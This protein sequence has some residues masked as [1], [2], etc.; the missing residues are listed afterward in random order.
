MEASALSLRSRCWISDAL[1]DQPGEEV[2]RDEK[3]AP[4]RIKLRGRFGGNGLI[5]RTTRTFE[6]RNLFA[7]GDEHVAIDY[8]LSPIAYGT[9]L[10]RHVVAGDNN[11]LGS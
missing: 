10:I 7:D 1:I 3:L 8:Q 6:R 4:F 2:W 11:G 5:E 9:G